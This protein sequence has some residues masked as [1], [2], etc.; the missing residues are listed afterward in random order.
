MNGT[1]FVQSIP[2]EAWQKR[3]YGKPTNMGNLYFTNLRNYVKILSISFKIRFS[4]FDK[5]SHAFFKIVCRSGF[6]L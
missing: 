4:L 3:F 5:C 1:K 2:A 6:L